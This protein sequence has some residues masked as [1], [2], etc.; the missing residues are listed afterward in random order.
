MKDKIGIIIQARMG[1]TR[2]P[3]KVLL[4]LRGKKVL[5]HVVSRCKKAK[6]DEVI[7]ATTTNKI[8]NAIFDFCKEKNIKCFR[9]SEDDVLDRY[10]QCAKEYGLKYVL[11]VT[12]DC[13]LIDWNIINKLIDK[14]FK[15]DLAYCRVDTDTFPRGFDCEVFS[16]KDLEMAFRNATKNDEREHVTIYIRKNPQ[17]F[18]SGLL[19]SEEDLS[20]MRLTL[21]T[22]EDYKLL[23][24]VFKNIRNLN[25]ENIV[26]YLK[27]NRELLKIN[28]N[29][30]Q[31]KVS[32][33]SVNKEMESICKLRKLTFEDLLLIKDW[34]N[35][36]IDVLR[37]NKKLT[38]N[39]QLN[40]WNK[41]K[42]SDREK[43][44]A[45]DGRDGNLV[46]Y[47]GF[48]NLNKE[49]KK[50]EISFL[51]KSEIKEN[52]NQFTVIFSETLK[53]LV[54]YGFKKLDL[55]RI[56]TETYEFR[57]VVI[58][59]LEKLNFKKEGVL[60][61]N[62]FKNGKYFDSIIQS[63]LCDDYKKIIEYEKSKKE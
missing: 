45:I 35:E 54:E 62:V 43:L 53:F 51:L 1:A 34:R 18:R 31:K 41:I 19:I 5:E 11:R 9:G 27:K 23:K 29:I 16:F 58:S 12:S 56:F 17:N 38:N 33:N 15:N 3:G 36:Q 63:M 28:Q 42:N 10:Y 50:A 40:Y 57:Q 22:K 32:V 24:E 8:D 59:I 6:V 26:S 13:P 4:D 60:R 52:S 44:F 46:G 25:F 21:D 39:D 2:L 30:K 37:Q 20:Y 55:N 61:E 7:V 47:G 14:Y 49:Y 48:V